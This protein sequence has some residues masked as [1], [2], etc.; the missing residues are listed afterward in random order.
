M[1]LVHMTS[2]DWSLFIGTL[3]LHV[4]SQ[5]QSQIKPDVWW[6]SK[7]SN[8]C[9]F[10]V[11]PTIL[12]SLSWQGRHLDFPWCYCASDLMIGSGNSEEC[13]RPEPYSRRH[14]SAPIKSRMGDS[15]VRD[16]GFM[17][18]D[19]EI[20]F[21]L[22][23]VENFLWFGARLQRTKDKKWFMQVVY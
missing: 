1:N 6:G 16:R 13:S 18:R 17:R 8:F 2:L 14:V 23:F 20:A 10:V 3:R 15:A 11:S 22:N 5:V 12:K 9:P 19:K 21:C 7:V 4:P